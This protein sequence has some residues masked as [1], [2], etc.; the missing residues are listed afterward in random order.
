MKY[1]VEYDGMK[2]WNMMNNNLTELIFYQYHQ[3]LSVNYCNS[4]S[5][6]IIHIGCSSFNM[7][8]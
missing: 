8:K 4:V 6:K 7:T 5:G 2:I 1:V 3:N